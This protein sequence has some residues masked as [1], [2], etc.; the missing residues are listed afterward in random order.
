MGFLRMRL[1]ALFFLLSIAAASAHEFP[2]PVNSGS[3]KG[4][5]PPMTPQDAAKSIKLPEGFKAT[6]FAGEPDVQNP[7]AC[8][9]DS[10]GRLWVAENYT[11]AETDKT[12]DHSM[13]DRI[14]IFEDTDN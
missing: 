9:W 12:F 1:P 6:L 13:R 7:I 8:A 4:V 11:Y 3:E 2:P 5:T 10:R 14:L